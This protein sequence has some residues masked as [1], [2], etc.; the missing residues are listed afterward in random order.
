MW[1]VTFAVAER[2]AGNRSATYL[3]D[4]V[5]NHSNVVQKVSIELIS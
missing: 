3:N 4:R 5:T 2:I 1:T